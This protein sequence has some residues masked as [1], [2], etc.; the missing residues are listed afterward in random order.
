MVRRKE[1]TEGTETRVGAV[2]RAAI[3]WPLS[4]AASFPVSL[5]EET[6]LRAYFTDV[7]RMGTGPDSHSRPLWARVPAM[8]FHPC[9][10]ITGLSYGQRE[11]VK[12]V[13]AAAGW[14]RGALG[15]L[16]PPCVASH[17]TPGY[18]S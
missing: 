16:L 3:V 1:G 18:H 10:F 15:S 11:Q 5:N 17:L 9:G 6:P 4:R 8:R 14:V 2:V 13:G 7:G 12:N